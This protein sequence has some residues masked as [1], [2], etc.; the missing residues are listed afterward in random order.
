MSIDLI[1]LPPDP[2]K[3][4]D[5]SATMALLTELPPEILHNILR[6][7][8]P[9]DLAWISRICKTLYYSIKDN[10]TLFKDVYL[11]HLDEPQPGHDVD[12]EQAL[13]AAIR[14]QTVC[15]RS[16]IAEKVSERG[17]QAFLFWFTTKFTPI[18]TPCTVKGYSR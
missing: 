14:L 8:D 17:I 2:G 9:E 5:A 4:V 6:F 10:L 1:V 18:N 7:V 3:G 12:W 13:K 15:R 11:A 16:S